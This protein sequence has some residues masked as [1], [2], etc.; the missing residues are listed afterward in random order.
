MNEISGRRVIGFVLLAIAIV[1]L[2]L[3]F[4]MAVSGTPAPTG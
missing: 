3:V 2:T 4:G 1:V